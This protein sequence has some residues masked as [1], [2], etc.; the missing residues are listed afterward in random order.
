MNM[1]NSFKY[2][3]MTSNITKIDIVSP[4]FCTGRR[5]GI[6]HSSCTANQRDNLLDQGSERWNFKAAINYC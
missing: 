6:R 4:F 5:T 3:N 1:K 2:D